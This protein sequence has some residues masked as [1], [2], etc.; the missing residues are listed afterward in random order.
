M[1]LI[2]AWSLVQV[3]QGPPNF[4]F[5]IIKLS[6]SIEWLFCY[7]IHECRTKVRA[8]PA[9]QGFDKALSRA[10]RGLLITPEVRSA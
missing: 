1:R 2:I 7:S 10:K 5:R 6:H 8:S 9:H 4:S 3:Q